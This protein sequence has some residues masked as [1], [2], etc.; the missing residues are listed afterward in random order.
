[1]FTPDSM[2]MAQL[3]GLADLL[4]EFVYA[5]VVCPKGWAVRL[6]DFNLTIGD[7]VVELV[8]CSIVVNEQRK[9]EAVPPTVNDAQ[10][11]SVVKSQ[12]SSSIPP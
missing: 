10:L 6:D 12:R 9:I 4:A 5:N 8:V 2:Y 3:V 1:M 7:A 11:P